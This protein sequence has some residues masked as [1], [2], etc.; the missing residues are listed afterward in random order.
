MCDF[1]GKNQ[2]FSRKKR[3]DNRCRSATL[4]DTMKCETLNSILSVIL[5]V[6]VVLGV[7]FALKL[8][9]IT[10]DSRTLQKMATRDGALIGQTQSLYNDVQAYNQKYPST[11]LTHILQSLQTK[12]LNH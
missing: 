11:E 12:P 2:F 4:R 9:F 3:V 8:A 10:R 1:G 6:L 7:Y 5:G